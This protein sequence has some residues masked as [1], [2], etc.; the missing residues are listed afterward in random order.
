VPFQCGAIASQAFA[1]VYAINS[2]HAF[3]DAYDGTN[4]KAP[5]W[6]LSN[7]TAAPTILGAIPSQLFAQVYG[8]T[9]TWVVGYANDGTGPKAALW[10]ATNLTATPTLFAGGV[11][12]QAKAIDGNHVVGYYDSGSGTR[13]ALWNASS[14]AT[15]PIQLG[16]IADTDWSG[17]FGISGDYIVGELDTNDGTDYAV[18]W[19]LANPTATPI[20]LG[21]QFDGQSYGS[22]FGVS[23]TTI[24]G[25]WDD[26]TEHAV[27]WNAANPT[28]SWV[29]FTQIPSQT[30]A[31]ANA[32]T[33]DLTVGLG[34]D[35]TGL[36][37]MWSSP[38]PPTDFTVFI[39]DV[40]IPEATL[41]RIGPT[42]SSLI[43]I[44][45]IAPGVAT[46]RLKIIDFDNSID[47]ADNDPVLIYDP[48]AGPGYAFQGSV[49]RRSITIVA[50]Y[51]IWD[52]YCADLNTW[53]DQILVGTPDGTQFLEDP[54]GTFTPYDPAAVSLT[55]DS[56]TVQA[57]FANYTSFLGIN[58]TTYVETI[59]LNLTGKPIR[60]NTVTLRSALNDILGLV[61]NPAL[62]YW[63]DSDKYLHWTVRAGV[64]PVSGGGSAPGPLVRL[65][66]FGTTIT[67]T[68]TLTDSAPQNDIDTFNYEN[69]TVDYDDSGW[70]DLVYVNGATT[71]TETRTYVVQYIGGGLYQTWTGTDY[72]F[73]NV[74]PLTSLTVRATASDSGTNLGSVA[75]GSVQITTGYNPS[76]GSY[77][78]SG[79]HTDWYS[80]RFSGQT[81]WIHAHGTTPYQNSGLATGQLF[82]CLGTVETRTIP[83]TTGTDT[84][85]QTWKTGVVAQPNGIRYDPTTP[86]YLYVVDGN[87][88]RIYTIR[89]SDRTIT[90]SVYIGKIIPHPLGLSGDPGDSTL[91][92]VLNAPW[93]A[94]GSTGGNF[95]AKCRKSDNAVIA[96][97]TLASGRWSAIK[98]SAAYIWL[99]N[100]DTDRIHKFNKTTGAQ[101]APYSISYSGETQTNP[102]GMWV[103]GTTLGLF[104]LSHQRFLKV[105]ESAPTT[106]TGVQ[107]TAGYQIYGGEIDTTTH[108]DLYS[109][110][111]TQVL[112]FN[113][114]TAGTPEQTITYYVINQPG[115]PF[116]KYWIPDLA[117]R[118]SLSDTLYAQEVGG[119]GWADDLSPTTTTVAQ[120]R[121]R[122]LTSNVSD[123]QGVRDSI[124]ST[125]LQMGSQAVVRGSCAIYVDFGGWLPGQTITVVSVPAA[126]NGDYLIQKATT[127]FL[128]GRGDRKI[129]L[130]WGNAPVGTIGLRRGAQIPPGTIP[131]RPAQRM[132]VTVS[133]SA[134]G[135][136]GTLRVTA[137]AVDMSGNPWP[138]SGKIVN[139]S[140]RAYDGDANEVTAVATV[141]FSPTTSTTNIKGEAWTDVT[142]DTREATSY[143]ISA[144]MAV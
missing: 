23:G 64:P 74:K 57:L 142:L 53:L 105:D 11:G 26:S 9:D 59:A 35:P 113:L 138:I 2:T 89:Q 127:E 33:G 134:P 66:P 81:G 110:T 16:E 21:G 121:Q 43:Q 19:S 92:W 137:Q 85:K 37:V 5:A 12:A 68:A 107:S 140:F 93:Q 30:A 65:F 84:W 32:T 90:A 129:T 96:T 141:S 75:S 51:R 18:L 114:H 86:G 80:I 10:D 61:A 78:Y 109:D 13:A 99:T 116:D 1:D 123:S 131:R 135:A 7:P 4:I 28:A 87:T 79:T 3:G 47:I 130:E 41:F 139:W 22:A 122:L 100:L 98:V 50:N 25:E 42:G 91:Y 24:V 60:W 49:Q 71:F 6:D 20:I 44:E 115:T 63:I 97:Y 36:A 46:A 103:D 143:Y 83:A 8:A 27:F 58:T 38:P 40:A 144:S 54:P 120:P 102:T 108:H 133:N 77:T 128:S 29:E 111:A 119:S 112:K 62:R 34:Q 67:P 117:F 125:A 136:G 48:T 17:A 104:F 39:N 52:V 14:P 31:W 124:G 69:L 82:N 126:L 76:G 56:A 118:A 106:V 95:I 45:V 88:R 132:L 15:A 70:A 55:S 73:G 94:T 101:I 72:I